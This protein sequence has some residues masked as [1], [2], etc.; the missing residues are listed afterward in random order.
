MLTRFVSVVLTAALVATPALA[1]NV[2][3]A[4]GQTS[5]QSTEC[6]EPAT[7]ASLAA[8]PETPANNINARV[9]DYNAYVKLSQSYMDC[10]ANEGQKDASAVS[11]SVVGAAQSV[12]EDEQKKVVALA[13]PLK[14]RHPQPQPMPMPQAQ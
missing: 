7:P 13:G 3:V 2:S 8:G 9:S 11:T 6:T 10:L 14:G 5:W 1:G 4:N 12:I